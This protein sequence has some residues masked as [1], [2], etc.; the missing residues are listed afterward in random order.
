M[1]SEAVPLPQENLGPVYDKALEG[2]GPWMPNLPPMS[3]VCM[4]CGKDRALDQ[5]HKDC[6][7]P[8]GLHLRCRDC[9]GCKPKDFLS[10]CGLKRCT[11]CLEIKPEEESFSLRSIQTGKRDSI[12][13]ACVKIRSNEWYKNN[14]ER[15]LARQKASGSVRIWQEKQRDKNKS[16]LVELKSH[17][18]TDC[19]VS[20]PPWVM[21][22][23]HRDENLKKGN[24]STLAY[25]CACREVILNEAKKCDLVCANCHAHRTHFRRSQ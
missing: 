10:T 14:K 23:D 22:F 9:R 1:Y 3:K 4:L 20:Y 15:H 17:P 12:C 24:L 7:R 6:T 21:Q 16:L 8:D 25:N 18:C 11:K 5:F 2:L 13:R 19:H